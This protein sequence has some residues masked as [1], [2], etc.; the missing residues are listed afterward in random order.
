MTTLADR[1][2]LT[3]AGVIAIAVGLTLFWISVR[4]AG[5]SEILDA[6]RRLGFGFV[7]VFALSA[8]RE[9]SRTLAWTLC[10]DP[11][12]RLRFRDAFPARLTG[13]ALGN[14][15]PLG[16]LV[17]EPTKAV[18]VRH[19]LPLTSALA[20]ALVETL[21]YSVTVA[22]VI[23]AGIAAFLLSFPVPRP[24]RIA[25][26]IAL[27]GI[28]LIGVVMVWVIAARPKLVTTMLGWL[29]DRGVA[30]P[31]L[32]GRLD[33]VRAAEERV[34]GFF[35]RHPSRLLRVCLLDA[36]FHAAGVAEVYVTLAF[37]TDPASVTWLAAFVLEA[38]NRIVT[39]VF[40]VVPL[41]LGVDEAAAG[42]VSNVLTLGTA[43][44]VA[45]AI[46]RK[47]RVL[48]WSALGIGF[49]IHRGLSVRTVLEE[50]QT[51]VTGGR[52]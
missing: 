47:A 27:G 21:F 40:K 11:P 14:L 19:R 35:V 16:L 34:Y 45:L 24:V 20:A 37:M 13:E 46:V 10:V 5:V 48:C 44:G 6:I 25:S 43:S 22:I 1:R 39:V 2:R 26:L 42:L 36:A 50:T 52:A 33:N 32:A 7:A 12:H 51:E 49:L 3:P 4:R 29:H 17:S 15:T 31:M 23:A 28:L 9:V 8:V 30:Q 38:V 41:R 18:Y